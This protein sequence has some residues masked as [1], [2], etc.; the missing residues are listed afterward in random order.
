MAPL[1][2]LVGNKWRHFWHWQVTSGATFGIMNIS[3][4]LSFNGVQDVEKSDGGCFES[5]RDHQREHVGHHKVAE[6]D[7]NL[8]QGHSRGVGL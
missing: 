7:D 3:L 4:H 8:E 6:Y 2:A 1:L 5:Q